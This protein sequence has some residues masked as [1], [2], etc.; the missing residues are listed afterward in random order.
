ML[1]LLIE[2]G[3]LGYKHVETS[4]EMN[5]KLK[6]S[7]DQVPYDKGRY[8]RLVGKLIYLIQGRT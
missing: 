7:V 8:Q 2:I 6:E 1:D 4:I 5:H 3:M